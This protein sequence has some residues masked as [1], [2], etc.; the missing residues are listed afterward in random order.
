MPKAEALSGAAPAACRIFAAIGEFAGASRPIVPQRLPVCDRLEEALNIAAGGPPSVMALAVAIAALSPDL[1][2]Q[3]RKGADREPESFFD[4]HANALVVGP[5][6]IEDRDDVQIGLSLMAPHVRYPDH[7]HP[8]EEVYVSLAGGAWRNEIEDWHEPGQ[9][10]L[11]YN[12]PGIVHA[13]RTDE[14][15][16]L[17]VWCLWAG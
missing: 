7:A 13:M 11:V 14:Q 17:A 8:P 16:L 5:G 1:C 9:G 10:G 12:P 4:G 3:R 2:W 6:G 15:P